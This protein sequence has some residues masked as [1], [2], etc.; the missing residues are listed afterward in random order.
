MDLVELP[1]GRKPIG[2]KWAFKKNINEVGQVMKCKA[3]LVV[4]GYSHVEGVYFSQIFSPF[5]K[6]PSIRVLMS[7]ARSFDLEI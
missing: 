7:L 5:E 2:S 6:L 4:K 1:N 3:R